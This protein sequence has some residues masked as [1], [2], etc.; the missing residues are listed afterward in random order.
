LG[1]ILF[2]SFAATADSSF[3]WSE[4]SA[5]KKKSRDLVEIGGKRR[6]F[7]CQILL[8]SVQKKLLFTSNFST[9]SRT[10][11]QLFTG[12][13]QDLCATETAQLSMSVEAKAPGCIELDQA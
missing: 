13:L 8:P 7:L 10:Q 11:A 12:L 1:T 6:K 9:N 2:L 5:Q 3:N 4:Y